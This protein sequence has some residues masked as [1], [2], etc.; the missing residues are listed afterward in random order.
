MDTNQN[1]ELGRRL[2]SA[3]EVQEWFSR[4][5]TLDGEPYTLDRDQAA[6]VL[7]RHKNTLVTARAGSGKTRVIVAKVAYLVAVEQ[8]SLR[9]IAIFM[10][11][12][13]AAAEVNQR[14]GW[15]KVDDV[16]LPEL[17]ARLEWR[18]AR[19]DSLASSRAEMSSSNPSQLEVRSAST[20]HK[21]ALDTV[22]ATGLKPEI[23]D[24]A[25]HD[26]LVRTELKK[27][28]AKA[29]AKFSPADYS[30]LLKLTNSFIARAGQKFC[31][32]DGLAELKTEV[33]MYFSRHNDDED[34]KVRVKIHQLALMTYFGYLEQLRLP[35]IDFNLLMQKATT[36]LESAGSG[37]IFPE[38]RHKF[39]NLQY[40]MVDEYQDFSYL[41]YA[42]IRALRTICPQA[43]LFA[44]GDDWQAIN[45]FAGSDVDYFLN[46]EKYFPEDYQNI[47]LLTN[48]RSDRVIVENA[49]DYML[50]HYSPE[51][52]RAVPFS[53]KK[54]KIYRTKLAKTKFDQTDILED[55]LGDGRYQKMLIEEVK[56]A[57]KI[58]D[59]GENPTKTV[60][61]AAKM[62]KQCLKI[63]KQNRKKSIMLLHRHNF[64]SIAGV[65]LVVFE[66]ALRKISIQECIMPAEDFDHQVRMMTMHKS[67]GL[68]ADVV[69][70]LE[71][72]RAQVLSSHPFATMF[73]I[74]EDNLET[75]KADQHRLLYVA[76]TRARHRLYILSN[77]QEFLA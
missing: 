63:L 49:N 73:E 45:R 39:Q 8:I 61:P 10:F 12:R 51:A 50:K 74:F 29:R 38:L 15:V 21:F 67:K 6:A 60:L 26:R 46:F 18:A 30:D 28:V 11:N 65:D 4:H 23:I 76:L 32:D 56:R 40:I 1:A 70:L 64:T 14:I 22:K 19:E 43:H 17:S 5:V 7:D 20:F 37:Q 33:E 36:I 13:T 77:D 31:G 41:F 3:E 48:Y 59:L 34:Y 55:G 69:I 62:L 72:D 9:E 53:K 75:E 66:R 24:E 16:S 27:F 68:E 54:G 58:A 42:I 25:T 44:V 47:P 35:K 52:K 71:L 2:S 57:G